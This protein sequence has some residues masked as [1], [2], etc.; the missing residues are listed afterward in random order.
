LVRENKILGIIEHWPRNI[1]RNQSGQALLIVLAMMT[2]GC[3][4]IVPS[5]NFA[6]TNIKAAN[7]FEEKMKGLYTAEAGIEDA[8]WLVKNSPPAS[9]PYSYDLNDINNMS[10]SVVIEAVSSIAG[11]EIGATGVHGGWLKVTQST[12]WS[13]GVYTYT[14][15][16]TN[17]GEG[18]MRI[19][20]IL[21]DFQPDLEYVLGSTVSNITTSDPSVIGTPDSGITLFW[22]IPSP[23]YIIGK[24]QTE[25]FSFQLNGLEMPELE[26]H[27]MIKATREDVGVVW[28]S[29]SLPYA[30][31]SQAKNASDEVIASIKVGVWKYHEGLDITCWQIN[32]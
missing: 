15:Q 31:T 3:L 17:N 8:L 29:D 10:A 18:N 1:I 14:L 6:A 2:L 22:D 23:Y 12:Q 24:N 5:L 7:M 32:P 30:I 20:Q 28:D 4:M 13:E 25:Y 9:L 21:V 26:S 19:E 11:V 27:A 16:M